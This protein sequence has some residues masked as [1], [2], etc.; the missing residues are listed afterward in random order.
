MDVS[1]RKIRQ[2]QHV[3]QRANELCY[4]W[5]IWWPISSWNIIYAN[6]KTNCTQI[7][8]I[9]LFQTEILWLKWKKSRS[10]SKWIHFS[11]FQSG[12]TSTVMIFCLPAE[13]KT[14]N[15]TR[16]ISMFQPKRTHVIYTDCVMDVVSVQGIFDRKK[17]QRNVCMKKG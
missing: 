14:S 12:S 1:I 5:Y 9:F 10:F 13:K 8:R 4:Q 6:F 17:R 2:F 16:M 7:L 3:L 11:L 15:C